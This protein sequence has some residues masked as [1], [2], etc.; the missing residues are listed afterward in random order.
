MYEI[1]S[2]CGEEDKQNLIYDL[3]FRFEFVTSRDLKNYC[4]QIA[5]HITQSWKLRNRGTKIVAASQDKRPDGSQF[6]VQA[7]KITWHNGRGI[8]IVSINE[9]I[10]QIYPGRVQHGTI[11][12]MRNQNE[13]FFLDDLEHHRR[14]FQPQGSVCFVETPHEYGVIAIRRHAERGIIVK[15]PGRRV[16]QVVPEV[17]G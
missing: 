17:D 2:L 6:I 1:W 3:L 12:W 9:G 14:G 16:I 13:S 15:D 4:Q 10:I 11:L 8:G 5:D 7:I